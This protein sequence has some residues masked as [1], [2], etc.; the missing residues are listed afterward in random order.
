MRDNTYLDFQHDEIMEGG[1]RA[2]L[3]RAETRV[4]LSNQSR[5]I[6]TVQTIHQTTHTT[7]E[8]TE[9]HEGNH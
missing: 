8:R 9:R 2:I 3:Q 6:Q 7:S 1:F 5:H 4:R